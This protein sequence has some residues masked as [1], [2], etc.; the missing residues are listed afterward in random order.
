MRSKVFVV[1]CAL[2]FASSFAHAAESF[3]PGESG[4]NA[5][6]LFC[7]DFNSGAPTS[8]TSGTY[9]EWNTGSGSFTWESDVGYDGSAGMKAHWTNGQ[10]SAGW[11]LIELET[12]IGSSTG[13]RP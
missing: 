7:D 5:A 1:A 8:G 2:L 6:V 3:C 10:V 13:V 4:H 11:L 12:K 9:L